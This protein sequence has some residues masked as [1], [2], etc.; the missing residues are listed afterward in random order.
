VR[1]VASYPI[2]TIVAPR[3]LAEA[4]AQIDDWVLSLD[5][6]SLTLRLDLVARAGLHDP[7]MVE[8][9]EGLSFAEGNPPAN[10]REVVQRL[11]ELVRAPPA[12]P[13]CA[14][15]SRIAC[16]AVEQPEQCLTTACTRGLD[17]FAE[18]LESGFA[19]VLTPGV[20]LRLAGQAPLADADGDLVPDLVGR[21]PSDASAM[22][23]WAD[24]DLLLGG[25]AVVTH[26]A[27]FQGS[28]LPANED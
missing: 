16:A 3:P 27:T 14:A 8:A 12:D 18:Y 22:G 24:I 17:A 19:A 5:R 9:F 20:D 23:V 11:V 7:V 13:G 25:V 15:L 10:A 6:H 21:D 4:V 1:R 2:G 28:R 26:S